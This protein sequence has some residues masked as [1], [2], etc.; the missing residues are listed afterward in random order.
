MIQS[1]W[2]RPA[3]AL[4]AIVFAVFFAVISAKGETFTQQEIVA[5]TILAEARG[6]GKRGMYAVACVISK[7]MKERKKTGAQVCLQ[8]WQFSC[9]NK[10]DPQRLHLRKLLRHELAPYAMMLAKNIDNLQLNFVEFANHYHTKRV[11]PYWSKG[12]RPVAT[13]GNHLF[14]RL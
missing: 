5:I 4:G 6:E 11:K 14:F 2:Y 3:L 9:W 8:P 1:E 12:K 7:R 10:N 13:I